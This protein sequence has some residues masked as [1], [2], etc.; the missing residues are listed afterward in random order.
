MVA[1]V[2]VLATR[3]GNEILRRGGNAIDA[4]VAIGYTLAVVYPAAGNLG[5]GGFMTIRFADGRTTFLDFREKAPLA[6]TADM[7]LD[8]AGNVIPEASILGY[9]AAAVPGSVAG[10]D[11]ALRKYGRMS[12][13][14]VMTPAIA[15]AEKGF[16]LTDSDAAGLMAAA[17][18]FRKDPPSAAIFLSHG[19]PYGPG[20]VLVQKDLAKVLRGIA[21][22]GA[23]GFYH[24]PVAEKIVA[25]SRANGGLL[26]KTDFEQYA[27]R[28]M[29]P[30]ACSY[31]GYTL[32]SAPPPSS[33][34]IALCEILN[35]LEPYPL[36]DWG[37][38]SAKTIHYMVE[39]MRHAYVDRDSA[40]GDPD[41]V[42]NPVGHLL[43]KGYAEAV[44]AR[45]DPDKAGNSQ[46]LGPGTPPH[47]G[48]E[49]THYSVVDKDGNA[50]GVT[51][52]LN[53]FFGA[54]VTPAGTGI[55]LNDT[56]D[57]FTL[58]PGVPNIFGLV[59]GEANRI[60]PHKTPLSSMSPTVVTRD[61]KAVMVLGS[62]GGPRI[63][64]IVLE[65]FLDMVDYGMNVQEAVDAPRIHHQWRP[66]EIFV[67]PFALSADTRAVLEG[68]G[69]KLV[70]QNPWGDSIAILTGGP[71]IGKTEDGYR[72]FGGVDDRRAVRY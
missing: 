30:I 4:A 70:Q 52:S 17:E 25:A 57:D 3:V 38:N 12:R 32:Y 10:F 41:F 53:N 72:C 51:Y 36:R 14:Q 7:Y 37:F 68:M 11:L 34:G 65:T 19:Q 56:M 18:D 31:K 6:A 54:R 29:K 49:T 39:A 55:L 20:D 13:R 46:D 23:D 27:V 1:S 47:E 33:G 8:Q 58:K 9:R 2:H 43:D 21:R 71:A 67:E 44:R 50:V 48:S 62:A 42:Q 45:I 24:G 66:D 69:Y 61:G 15:L 40:L 35:I 64:T 28:E 16:K 5:G 59:Q 26:S 63:I 60:A 22:L